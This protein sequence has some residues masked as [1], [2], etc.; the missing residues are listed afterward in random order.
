MEAGGSGSLKSDIN[1]TPLVDVMLVML[2]IFMLVT[3]MLQKGVA[4]S[5]PKAR[6]IEGVSEDENQVV[7]VAL[8]ESGE[9]YIGPDQIDKT[10]LTQVLKLKFEANPALQLQIKGD[11]N[12][13]YG[14]VKKIIQAGREAGFGGAAMIAEEIKDQ[15]GGGG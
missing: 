4:V 2:I 7:V 5:L 13:R 8:R 9:L 10:R 3:P 1:V 11:G 6:N 12:V 14:E 15:N